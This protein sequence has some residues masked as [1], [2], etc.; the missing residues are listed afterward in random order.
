[1]PWLENVPVGS[2]ID[3]YVFE[4]INGQEV[5]W[6]H[7]K[8]TIKPWEN[9]GVNGAAGLDSHLWFVGL[10]GRRDEDRT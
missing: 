5:A 2:K 4:R 6:R 10:F 1:M 9:Q 3:I 7:G 8:A